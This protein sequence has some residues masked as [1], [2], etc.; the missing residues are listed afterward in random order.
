MYK[1]GTIGIDYESWTV[2]SPL[3]IGNGAVFLMNPNE[4][5]INN[6]EL[7]I[8]QL[9]IPSSSYEEAI[10]NVQGKLNDNSSWE[11]YDITFT[12][13]PP[14][15]IGAN[16]VANTVVPNNCEVWFDGCNTCQTNN[17]I[18]GACTRIMCFREETPYCLRTTSGH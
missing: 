1:L 5:T 17:G 6:G 8:G 3:S 2:D 9:T 18:L 4:I 10:I 15:I 13:N 16:T 14:P 12:L 7:I 11:Q